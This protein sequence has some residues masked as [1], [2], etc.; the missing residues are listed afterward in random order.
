MWEEV[1]K[2]EREAE[3]NPKGCS[4][5]FYKYSET[6]S[7]GHVAAVHFNPYYRNHEVWKMNVQFNDG[8]DDFDE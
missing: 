6:G 4:R 8:D 1:R 3:N 7:H 5:R 2:H